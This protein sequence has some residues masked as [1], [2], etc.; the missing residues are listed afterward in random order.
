MYGMLVKAAKDN[1]SVVMIGLIGRSGFRALS[2]FIVFSVLGP[3]DYGFFIIAVGFL[4][5]CSWIPE[6]GLDVTSVRF[7]AKHF[8]RGEKEEGERIFRLVMILKAVA[9][10]AVFLVVFVLGPRF[11]EFFYDD[12]GFTP[13]IRIA[14]IGIFSVAFVNFS[15]SYF[16]SL[17]EFGKN[18]VIVSLSTFSILLLVAIFTL[19][20]RLTPFTALLA[21]SA[22]PLAAFFFSLVWIP[23]GLFS[24]DTG[25]LKKAFEVVGFSRWIYATNIIADFRLW[26]PVFF[27]AK[28]AEEAETGFYGFANQGAKIIAILS[29]SILTV[30][31]PRASG[32]VTPGERKRFLSRAYRKILPLIVPLFLVIFLT[33]PVVGFWR[34]EYLPLAPLF[35]LIYCGFLFTILAHPVRTVIYSKGNPQVE[36]LIEAVMVVFIFLLC[37]FLVPA[38]GALGAASAMFIQ[39]FVSFLFFM[40]YG[41]YNY[42]RSRSGEME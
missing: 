24:L 5:V 36:T 23:R 15:S 20:D 25:G 7:G 37:F 2:I 28:L 8:Q 3:S 41:Y 18:A 17:E 38:Y 9:S 34:E 33:K 1:I 4:S 16:K 31:L 35:N 26:L 29:S 21:F 14:S 13:L 6:L 32:K 42:F 39:R 11:A 30:L 10:A 22:G 19:L 12:E 27:L 40:S